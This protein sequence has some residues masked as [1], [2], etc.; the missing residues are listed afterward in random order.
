MAFLLP[1]IVFFLARRI[2]RELKQREG[3]PL[4]GST[5]VIT[6]R[7]QGGGFDRRPP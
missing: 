1:V 7:N 2:A 5:A 3:H 6:S 4:R